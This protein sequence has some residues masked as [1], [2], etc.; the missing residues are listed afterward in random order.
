MTVIHQVRVKRAKPVRIACIN[1]ATVP[2]GISFR[3]LTAALQKCYDRHFLPV[4]GYPVTLYNTKR[5]KP[6]EWRFIYFNNASQAGLLGYHDLTKNG[7]PV[8]RVYVKTTQDDGD[9]VSVT[10]SH[11]LFEMVIDPLANLWAQATRRT[12]YAYEM[13]DPVEEDTFKVDGI[14]MSN[15]LYPAWFEPF[16][17]PKGTKF[18]HL[19]LLKKPFSMSKGGYVILKRKGRVKEKFASK[20]KAKRFAEENRLG[21]RSEH[22]K[23]RG[24]RI[25]P[26]QKRAVRKSR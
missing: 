17:H 22:R 25:R 19:G 1:K 11:E 23:P 13:C 7:Q 16:K 20:A 3:K 4:W 15:F 14:E 10:A 9:P 24:R 12:E 2:L 5:A 6:G 21:H 18:D 26:R 8:S